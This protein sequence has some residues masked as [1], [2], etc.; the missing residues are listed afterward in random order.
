MSE[1]QTIV[2]TIQIEV[3]D[4]PQIRDAMA[5]KQ[6]GQNKMMN[7]LCKVNTHSVYGEEESSTFKRYVENTTE[8]IVNSDIGD[9][10]YMV[11]RFD[12][13]IDT[14]LYNFY[15]DFKKLMYFG[16]LI[17]MRS[18]KDKRCNR[19]YTVNINTLEKNSVKLKH[20][21][22]LNIE[23]YDKKNECASYPYET[24]I[25]FRYDRKRR[26]LE[27]CE[28]YFYTTIELINAMLGNIERVNLSMVERLIKLYEKECN[29]GLVKSF[30]EFVRKYNDYFYTLDIL[31]GVYDGIGLKGSYN[32]WL[33]KF[34]ITNNLYFMTK[35]DVKEFI[36]FTV[37]SVKQYMK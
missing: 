34:R 36:R 24:R 4:M 33:K 21:R 18:V 19:W 9:N 26:E 3:L 14:N 20:S 37:K 25:E 32:T 13:A 7:A 8:V 10:K 35:T 1:V 15:D 17:S 29:K 11:N 23:I 2:D 28:E 5:I 6:L 27:K 12:I 16:E 22:D 30:S 31:K